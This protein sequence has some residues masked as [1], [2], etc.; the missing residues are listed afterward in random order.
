MPISTFFLFPTNPNQNLLLTSNR[1]VFGTAD[2]KM[3]W[4]N[5]DLD[6]PAFETVTFGQTSMHVKKSSF[7]KMRQIR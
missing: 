4:S 2:L 5:E 7:D 6:K 3:A 1:T